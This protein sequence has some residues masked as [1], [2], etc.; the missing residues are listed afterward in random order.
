MRLLLV[1]DHLSLAE[2]FHDG[3]SRAGFAVD[4]ADS[5]A[6]ARAL[7]SKSDYDLV[8]LDLGLPDGSGLQLLEEWRDTAGTPVIVLTA[9]GR[10]G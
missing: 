8:L 6:T 2:A 1:E 10:L 7:F 9:R 3:L 5:L 4:P